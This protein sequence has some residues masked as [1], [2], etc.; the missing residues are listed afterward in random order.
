MREED[1]VDA[2][3]VL[4]LRSSQESAEAF[5][6]IPELVAERGRQ[7]VREFVAA[8]Q[9]LGPSMKAQ[10]DALN[11]QLQPFGY[12]L[13]HWQAKEMKPMDSVF[14]KWEIEKT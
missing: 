8:Y 12:S 3:R 2:R 11:K 9:S 4:R 7:R 13:F 6:F 5:S 10:I 1:A 14:H